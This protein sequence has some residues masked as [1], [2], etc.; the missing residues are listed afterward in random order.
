MKPMDNTA[1]TLRARIVGF[2]DEILARTQFHQSRNGELI[3]Q[4]LAEYAAE[5]ARALY[6]LTLGE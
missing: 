4:A 1:E 2:A 3:R 5:D 6:L